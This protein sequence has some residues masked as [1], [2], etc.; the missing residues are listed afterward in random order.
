[1]QTEPAA[2]LP[3]TAQRHILLGILFM[4]ST[5]LFFPLMGR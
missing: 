4:C 3:L 2:T 5:A 1:V